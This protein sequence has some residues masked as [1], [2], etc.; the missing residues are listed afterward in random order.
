MVYDAISQTDLEVVSH[1]SGSV[2]SSPS[3]Q[4]T[5]QQ[6]GFQQVSSDAA[7]DQDQGTN[8]YFHTARADGHISVGDLVSM[9]RSMSSAS[10]DMV[11]GDEDGEGEGDDYGGGSDNEQEEEEEEGEEEATRPKSNS[12][13]RAPPRIDTTAA[14]A[15]NKQP[16]SAP[17]GVSPEDEPALRSPISDRPVPLSHP[18][19]NLQSLQG[20]Y[21]G[22]VERLERS[23]ERM[24]SS[25][26]DI[27]SEI[28]KLDLEQKRRNSSLSVANE[29]SP[30]SPHQSL[31][32]S[33]RSVTGASAYRL[34][35]VSEHGNDGGESSHHHPAT[36]SVPVIVQ[37]PP[38]IPL[39]HDQLQA[40]H[41]H[42]HEHHDIE[43]VVSATSNDTYEQARVLFSNFDGVHYAPP[44][45]A[46][47]QAAMAK[48]LLAQ[49]QQQPGSYRTDKMV[50]YPA[51]I[52]AALNLPPRLSETAAGE[53]QRSGNNSSN[54]TVPGLSERPAT[55][56]EIETALSSPVETLDRFLDD[57]THAPVPAFSGRF[58]ANPEV[59]GNLSYGKSSQDISEQ[60][61][62]RGSIGMFRFYKKSATPDNQLDPAYRPGLLPVS[63]AQAAQEREPH[64]EEEG[65]EEEKEK[66][67]FNDVVDHTEEDLR[68][69]TGPPN[70]LVAELEERKD[71]L[72]HRTRTANTTGM[73]STLLQLDAVAQRQSENRRQ[74]PVTMMANPSLPNI[75]DIEDEMP[76]GF[77]FPEKPHIPADNRPPLGLLERRQL[78]EDEPLSKRR[79]RLQEQQQGADANREPDLEPVGRSQELPS[80]ISLPGID[81]DPINSDNEE[82]ETLAQRIKR[83]KNKNRNST[84]ARSDFTTE[85]LAE[86]DQSKDTQDDDLDDSEAGETLAQRRTRLQQDTKHTKPQ[87]SRY[88]KI[89]RARRSTGN[90][91]L[92]QPVGSNSRPLS[93]APPPPPASSH[94]S[95]TSL[96]L[97]QMPGQSP[98]VGSPM[99]KR[100]SYGYGNGMGRP[101]TFYG[102]ADAAGGVSPGGGVNATPRYYSRTVD[103]LPA[104]AASA[105]QR[106]RE[107]TIDRWRQS[108]V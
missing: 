5:S 35:Q 41:G 26:T 59:Y 43:R 32:D 31:R 22:N 44:D 92:M 89:P 107:T 27:A 58:Y 74:R 84:A 99:G 12:P 13:R 77:M 2:T 45:E 36:L 54:L 20:A 97:H 91:S 10:Y 90:V 40:G 94:G 49:Q 14:I 93:Y 51:P 72:K 57:S 3:P 15:S 60:K 68:D 42:G 55:A 37:P 82:G 47:A 38:H 21:L 64:A 48:S 39:D 7:E 83:L 23:A 96:S 78:E 95:R 108:V 19:P 11:D 61:K 104:M 33:I 53:S 76:L 86:I 73:R 66:E 103:N 1:A 70:S 9:I 100:N 98:Y 65:E 79:A 52:P 50:Y 88:A 67:D 34:A 69:Y 102:C 63:E 25:S 81:D 6:N 87:Q 71:E 28:R 46:Q 75:D 56:R 24:S 8:G 106:Q 62:K 105:E 4:T 17:V 85:V 30:A 16:Q 18:T 101:R 80:T 29:L